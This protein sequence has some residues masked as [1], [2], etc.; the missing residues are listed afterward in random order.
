MD[1]QSFFQ[2][3]EGKWISQRTTHHLLEQK[4]QSDRSDLWG[5]ILAPDHSDVVALCQQLQQDPT[6]ACCGLSIRW[7][8]VAE[9]YQSRFKPQQKGTALLVPL[10]ADP[11]ALSG[12]LLRRLGST[13]SLG[14]F[15]L[16]VDEALTLCFDGSDSATEERIWF[17]SPNLRLR[18][19][20]VRQ[21]GTIH[22]TAFCSEIRMQAPSPS[23]A[24]ASS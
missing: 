3:C 21:E 1:I 11:T 20:S 13:V 23:P 17:A 16:G 18:S 19:S 4:N 22:I 12:K 8:E 6:Q 9:A 14:T 5:E 24:E 10:P 2:L 7:S 15:S